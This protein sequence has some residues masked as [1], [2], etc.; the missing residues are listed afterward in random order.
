M[1]F[2]QNKERFESLRALAPVD[3]VRAWLDGAL[4]IGNEPAMIAAIRKDTR[5]SLS[6]DEIIDAV[7]DA[8]DEGLERLAD[9][10]SPTNRQPPPPQQAKLRRLDRAR[11][12]LK[13]SAA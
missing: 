2:P 11:Q 10:S 8:M 12:P 13:R 1:S 7:G 9:S 3:A 4:G 5:V 6:D